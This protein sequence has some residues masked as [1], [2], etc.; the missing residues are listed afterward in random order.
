MY[1]ASLNV[2]PEVG[3]QL[4]R[5]FIDLEVLSLAFNPKSLAVVEEGLRYTDKIDR[6]DWKS[7]LTDAYLPEGH[8]GQIPD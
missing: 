3:K 5:Q 4:I 6:V 7:L 1:A 8:K 2:D